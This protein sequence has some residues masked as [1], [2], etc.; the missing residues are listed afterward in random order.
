M[1]VHI[2]R[3]RVLFWV[4]LAIALL[5]LSARAEDVPAGQRVFYSGHSF[6][7]F[8]VPR[9]EELAAAAGIKEH[10]T[11]GSQMIGG[12]RVIQHWDLTGEKATAKPAL[13]GGQVDVFTM[14]PHILMPDAGID[15]FVELGLK[16]NPNMRFYVQASWVPF[17]TLTAKD[18]I[19]DNAQRDATDLDALQKA[20][21]TWRQQVEV[22]VDALNVK[23]G[24]KAVYI[25]P[26]G[27]AV[28]AL[29]RRVKIGEFPGMTKQAQ[30]FRDPIGHGNGQIM[31]LTAYCNFA[32]IY[33]TSPVGL[34]IT[35]R[36]I[37]EDQQ[38]ILQRIAWET[39]SKYERA[40]V[41]Q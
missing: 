13:T 36:G 30:L 6:H 11:A 41:K 29:R 22:Q 25:V 17:E 38:A 18:R 2:A 7:M 31:A 15:N 24:K 39:V 35:E 40:G 14:A 5:A 19:T 12:S 23:Y 33:K 34:K 28:M 27:D 32:A 20:G 37:S 21:D 16:N 8:I 1:L 26:V 9:I 3:R 10:H 4:P